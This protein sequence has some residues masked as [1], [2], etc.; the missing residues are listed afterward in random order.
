L[1]FLREG[2][3]I[4]LVG[5]LQDLLCE[6]GCGRRQRAAEIRDSLSLAIA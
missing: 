1:V 3:E 5:I 6:I 4:E 2:Q